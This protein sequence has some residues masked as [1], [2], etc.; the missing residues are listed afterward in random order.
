M[1]VPSTKDLLASVPV[2]VVVDTHAW[3][4]RVS[5]VGDSLAVTLEKLAEGRAE[6]P[7]TPRASFEEPGAITEFASGALDLEV[8]LYGPYDLHTSFLMWQPGSD[9]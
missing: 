4:Q 9:T 5:S 6:A 3:R 2:D 8:R 7:D 1:H